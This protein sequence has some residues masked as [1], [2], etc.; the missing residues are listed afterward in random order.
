MRQVLYKVTVMCSFGVL[1]CLR[2]LS[3]A[4]QLAAV[5][6]LQPTLHRPA[7]RRQELGLV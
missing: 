4:R 5:H 6:P 1:A 2:L 7:N 3:A